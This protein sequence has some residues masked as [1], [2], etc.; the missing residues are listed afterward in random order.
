MLSSNATLL[1][2]RLL[3]HLRRFKRSDTLL[4]Q[5]YFLKSAL[6]QS[7][8]LAIISI[9]QQCYLL[10]CSVSVHCVICVVRKRSACSIASKASSVSPSTKPSHVLSSN[11]TLL[12][13]RL[14]C[15]QR[16]VQ[17]ICKRL[18]PQRRT[19]SAHRPSHHM[20]CPAILLC[21]TSIN[22]VI[23]HQRHV[24]AICKRLLPQS[25]C[26]PIDQATT[27]IVQQ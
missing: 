19:L 3:C 8:D 1:C 16:H 27:C 5:I 9:L 11:A 18:L 12:C 13:Q 7:I 24:Q 4:C 20:Y 22:S 6:C 23:S 10:I 17:T 2:L 15:H 26:R 21:S 25:V 14:L